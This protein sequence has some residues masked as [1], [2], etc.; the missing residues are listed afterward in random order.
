MEQVK[1]LE[2]I[3]LQQYDEN[4]LI[5]LNKWNVSEEWSNKP[6]DEKVATN[7]EYTRTEH[8]E[9]EFLIKVKRFLSEIH[10]VCDITDENGYRI[11]LRDLQARFENFYKETKI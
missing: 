7:I 11:E 5:C 8:A 10:R 9:K 2:K 1:A 3:Y 4:T 6:C